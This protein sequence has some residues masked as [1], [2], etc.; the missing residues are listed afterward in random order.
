MRIVWHLNAATF[1]VLAI[2]SI[3]T[4][5]G[6]HFLENSSFSREPQ[7][8]LLRIHSFISSKMFC[9]LPRTPSNWTSL[10]FVAHTGNPVLLRVVEETVLSVSPREGLEVKPQISGEQQNTTR[11]PSATGQTRL[12][13]GTR[14]SSGES[15]ARSVHQQ[16]STCVCRRMCA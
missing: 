3:H 11:S 16:D 4:I 2:C 9:T 1:A 13:R 10:L 5:A 14:L 6:F 12:S 8:H 15:A 7:P